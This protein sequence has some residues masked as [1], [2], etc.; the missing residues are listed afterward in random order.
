MKIYVLITS[1]GEVSGVYS[2]K[3]KLIAATTTIFSNLEIDRV[4]IWETDTG[5]VDYLKLT[6]KQLLLLK[7]KTLKSTFH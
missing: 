4:E 6:K 7:I 2:T 3:D 5:F 1:N